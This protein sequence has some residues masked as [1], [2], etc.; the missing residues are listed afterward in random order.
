[1]FYCSTIVFNGFKHADIKGVGRA[2]RAERPLPDGHCEATIPADREHYVRRNNGSS[3]QSG[4][5]FGRH[6]RIL[7]GEY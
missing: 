5:R 6:I 2:S 4:P 1:M 3:T 7:N